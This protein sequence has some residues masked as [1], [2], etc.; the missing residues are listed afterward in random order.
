MKGKNKF[1]GTVIKCED[2][3]TERNDFADEPDPIASVSARNVEN[4]DGDTKN[5]L[6]CD[7]KLASDESGQLESRNSTISCTQSEFGGCGPE[8]VMLAPKK[9]PAIRDNLEKV[10]LLTNFWE[11]QISSKIVYRYEVAMHVGTPANRR[12]VDLL[13]G[14]RDDSSSTNRRKLCLNVLHYALEYY[15]ILSEGSGIVYDGGS[16]LFSSEDLAYALKEH[17]GILVLDVNDLPESIRKLILRVD[18]KAVTIE[19]VS[20]SA[21]SFD[22]SDLSAQM[23]RNLATLDRSLKQFYELITN[24]DALLSGRFTQFGVGCLYYSRPN[25]ENIGYGYHCFSGARKGIKFIEGKRKN[26]NDLIAALVLDHRTGLLFACQNLMRSVRELDGLKN[27]LKFDFSCVDNRMNS[28]WIQ[29]HQYVKGVRV[30]YIG[31]GVTNP[32]SFVAIGISHRP[33][34]ELKDTLPNAAKTEISVQAKF[35]RTGVP[36]NP[37]WP[38]VVWRKGGNVQYFPMELL[39]VAPN[40]R[41]PPEKQLIARQFQ[42]MVTD[43]PVNRFNKIHNL[44]EAL[45]LHDSGLKNDFLKAF[46]ITIAS[47]PMKIE[48]FRRHAP[49]I[50]YGV[51]HGC[52]MD[53]SD[54][55]WRQDSDSKYI[56]AGRVDRIIIVHS[57]RTNKLPRNVISALQQMFKTRGIRCGEFV[58]VGIE[59]RRPIETESELEKIFKEYKNSKESLL[60]IHIDRAENKL[61]DFLKLMERKYLIPTQQITAELAE[62]LPRK[63]RWISCGRT[64]IVGYDVAHPGKPTRDEV[65]NKM[66]PQ[67]PSVVGI[68]FNGAVHPEGFIGDYHFQTPL[69]EKVDGRL[70]NARFKWILDVFT[71]N[72]RVWPESVIITR[73]GVSEGQY[74]MVIEDELSAIKEACCEFGALHGKDPRPATIVDTEV[75][76]KDLTE[77]YMQSHKPIK[78]TAKPTA[79]QVIVDENEMSMDETQALLLALAFHHQ[80]AELPISL[81]EPVYQADE[82]AKRGKNLWNAYSVRHNFILKKERGKYANYPIDFEAMTGR[83]AFWYTKLQDRRMNA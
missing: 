27:V 72:R 75:V 69:Q 82:W 39:E 81:P 41:V 76:R 6:D 31:Y 30:N 28:K 52:K 80:V 68:S 70:L 61:H 5:G 54:Y 10:N 44:L 8:A 42:N 22:M 55:S 65:M 33:I 3:K 51:K 32:I 7:K 46:G 19:I 64:L 23:N 43:N 37:D 17:Y 53:G 56:K 67:K 13:R 24:Q 9:Q 11:L 29:V 4:G 15:R 47:S 1:G 62:R 16:M 36:I 12:A 49:G 57:D 34:K 21:A 50:L 73:D 83:L 25:S 2:T 14:D 35:S 26:P 71:K 48:G 78:G 18:A 77:F 60:I 40:Q 63:D 20:S 58:E 45:N 38:A 59:D 79:Y 74:R 66:P